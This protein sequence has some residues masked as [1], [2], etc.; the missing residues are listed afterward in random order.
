MTQV[1]IS[2]VQYGYS[3]REYRTASDFYK[4]QQKILKQIESGIETNTV[5]EQSLIREEMNMMV[6]EVRYDIAYSNVE[7]AYGNIFA[8]LGI[9]PFPINTDFDNLE[10]LSNS[11]RDYFEGLSLDDQFFS[12]RIE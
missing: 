1:H 8:S 2:L 12:M 4:T 10:L 6:A 9:D 11:I 3:Q 7:N 5:T